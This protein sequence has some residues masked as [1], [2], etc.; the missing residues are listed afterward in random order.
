[1]DIG[2][3]CGYRCYMWM[4]LPLGS[5]GGARLELLGRL[6]TTSFPW[7]PMSER[8]RVGCMDARM[9]RTIILVMYIPRHICCALGEFINFW[10]MKI[11]NNATVK[12]MNIFVGQSGV[13]DL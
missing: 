13:V 11:K 9:L 12:D 5:L 2:A 6:S 8:M 7:M 1:M 10:R 3:T 4:V